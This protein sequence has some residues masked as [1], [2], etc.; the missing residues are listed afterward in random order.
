MAVETSMSIRLV[1]AFLLVLAGACIPRQGWGQ[2]DPY[3][4][5]SWN[6]AQKSRPATLYSSSRIASAT[7]P[8]E[9]LRV[10]GTVLLPDGRTPAAGVT[11][12]A[13][14]RDRDGFDF[15]P[16]DRTTTTWRLQ[17]WAVTDEGGHFEFLT[18]RPA[19]D[20]LGR[21]GPHIHFTTD[22]R[23]F[24]RQWAPTL[25]LNGKP[26]LIDNVPTASVR[27]RLKDKPDF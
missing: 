22:S 6:E 19:P 27:I 23:E 10:R 9:P 18:I 16:G 14:H 3:W 7:E 24:G 21:D 12:H 15:G 5:R 4:M 26:E 2:A 25:F 8:G 17:G 13:Y 11:V 1:S 20:H